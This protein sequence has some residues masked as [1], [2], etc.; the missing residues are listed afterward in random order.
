ME[1]PQVVV[2]VIVLHD[3]SLLLGKDAET[4]YWT[5]PKGGVQKFQQIQAVGQTAI[6]ETTGIAAVVTGSIFISE[7][8]APPDHHQVVVVTMGQPKPD[9]DLTPIPRPDIFSEVRWVDFR[10]L[11]EY[12]ETVDNLTADA[13]MKFHI[14]LQS[15]ARGA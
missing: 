8:I 2:A 6:F 12:Q 14:Y 13:I 7:D 9:A 4:G 1:T 5:L 3:K 11:V 10:N 15:K